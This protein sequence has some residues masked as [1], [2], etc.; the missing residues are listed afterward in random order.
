MIRSAR[1][2]V[3]WRFNPRL[4][5]GGDQTGDRKTLGTAVVSI[6]ASGGEA[7]PFVKRYLP[8]NTMFQSTPPGGRRLDPC[9][10]PATS[11]EFQSTPP[12]GRRHLPRLTNVPNRKFQSTPPGGRRLFIIYITPDTGVSIHAS[13]GEATSGCSVALLCS[14]FNPRLRGGGDVG[15]GCSVQ[16]GGGVSIHASGGEATR[17]KPKRTNPNQGF[18]PRLRG[19]GD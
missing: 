15:V 18:N 19:G 6:H 13:G 10:H 3:G 14:G 11:P 9:T 2:P 12:G 7:T 16:S 1:M 8:Y 5:G 4:R 17:R